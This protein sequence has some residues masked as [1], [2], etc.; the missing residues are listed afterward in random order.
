VR[1]LEAAL[2]AANDKLTEF[3]KSQDGTVRELLQAAKV[4]EVKGGRRR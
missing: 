3:Q 2:V 4:Q 1:F